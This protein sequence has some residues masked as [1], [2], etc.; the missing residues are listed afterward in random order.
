MSIEQEFRPNTAAD[1]SCNRQTG[2]CGYCALTFDKT[3]W[4]PNEV[5]IQYSNIN[6][7]H[8]SSELITWQKLQDFS[9]SG[10]T[11]E[12]S[13]CCNSLNGN[14]HKLL[15]CVI[16]ECHHSCLNTLISALLTASAVIFV[17]IVSTLLI[18]ISRLGLILWDFNI[19]SMQ[20]L[21]EPY[22]WSI[23][24]PT[25]VSN[26]CKAMMFFAL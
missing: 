12:T 20:S 21:W 23:Q 5:F 14:N 10:I 3:V 6:E 4:D 1:E 11:T 15:L 18:V 22:F 2:L 17:A 26:I 16:S 13:Q 19:E 9:I 25:V 8:T 7:S 24:G